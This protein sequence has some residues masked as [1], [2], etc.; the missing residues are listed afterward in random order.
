MTKYKWEGLEGAAD[1]KGKKHALGGALS[2]NLALNDFGSSLYVETLAVDS[3]TLK[4][5][6]VGNNKHL[7]TSDDNN[8]YLLGVQ[9]FSTPIVI[10]DD[11][12]SIDVAFK[13][14]TGMNIDTDDAATPPLLHFFTGAFS[15]KITTQ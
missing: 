15:T 9:T 3:D 4:A 8:G 7:S 5:Y 14:S 12:G 6:L 13:V 11:T 1:A 10:T 2:D